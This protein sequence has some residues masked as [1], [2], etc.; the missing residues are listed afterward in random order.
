MNPPSKI[1]SLENILK[2]LIQRYFGSPPKGIIQTSSK[3][4]ISKEKGKGQ[5][6]LK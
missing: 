2:I 6:R 5:T 4:E 3:P 1:S